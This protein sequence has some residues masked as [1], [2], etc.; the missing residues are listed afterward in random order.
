MRWMAAT[1]VWEMLGTL[2]CLQVCTSSKLTLP[3]SYDFESAVASSSCR[4]LTIL[5]LLLYCSRDGPHSE[6]YQQRHGE[7]QYLCS[8]F[9]P[10]AA[11]T[12]IVSG[13]SKFIP[14]VL[15][16]PKALRA[17]PP[18]VP[19][20][21]DRKRRPVTSVGLRSCASSARLNSS[22]NWVHQLRP[23]HTQSAVAVDGVLQVLVFSTQGRGWHGPLRT[24]SSAPRSLHAG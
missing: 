20:Q 14:V 3:S 4:M 10:P 22:P 13:L 15:Y 24:S 18:I 12:C 7:L 2:H 1:A 17:A 9:A 5:L 6:A 11:V 21:V 23:H 8:R 16:C 19:T